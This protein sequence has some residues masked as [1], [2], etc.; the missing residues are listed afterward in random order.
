MATPVVQAHVCRNTKQPGQ[1]FGTGTERAR[2]LPGRKKHILCEVFRRLA[3]GNAEK[4]LN[5][6]H[7]RAVM[8]LDQDGKSIPVSSAGRQHE[9]LIFTGH[10][11]TSYNGQPRTGKRGLDKKDRAPMQSD[12]EER[13]TD[14]SPLK[15]CSVAPC[16]RRNP[17]LGVT[18]EA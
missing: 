11:P 5:E 14:S 7:N 1:N 6:L 4:P 9:V 10:Y 3:A 18:P 16:G 8:P 2:D 17:A 13:G 12:V 15:K